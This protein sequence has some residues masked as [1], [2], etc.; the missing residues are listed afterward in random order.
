M[1]KLLGIIVLGLLLN[2]NAYAGWFDKDKIIVK[3]CYDSK[4]YKNFKTFKKNKNTRDAD[5]FEI[6]I[7]LKEK[8]VYR[9]LEMD[10][11]LRIDQFPIKIKTN[12]YIIAHDPTGDLQF[13]LKNEAYITSVGDYKIQMLCK[14]K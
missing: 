5:K 1:K 2:G 10:G 8:I 4:N 3:E 12:D 9:I 13:D 7:N 6:E 14:F 11:K